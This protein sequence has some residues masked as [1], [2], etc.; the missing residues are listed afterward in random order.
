MFKACPFNICKRFVAK[1]FDSRVRLVG[2]FQPAFCHFSK[3]LFMQMFKACPFNI[4]KRFVAKLF[5]ALVPIVGG[6]ALCNKIKQHLP[7]FFKTKRL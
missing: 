4:C 2:V 7:I 3:V 6:F 1:L 5:V